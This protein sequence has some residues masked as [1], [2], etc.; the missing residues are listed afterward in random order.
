L[1]NN[2]E[3]N[4]RCQYRTPFIVGFDVIGDHVKTLLFVFAS[5]HGVTSKFTESVEA[6]NSNFVGGNTKG[7]IFYDR[8]LV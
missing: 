5:V 2:K 6:I 3:W 8:T 1:L 4:L 7:L